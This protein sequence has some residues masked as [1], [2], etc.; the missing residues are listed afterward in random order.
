MTAEYKEPSLAEINTDGLLILETTS[1]LRFV[2]LVAV[3]F[4]EGPGDTSVTCNAI[5]S[6]QL[7]GGGEITLL[8]WLMR[9]A[10]LRSCLWT[11]YPDGANHC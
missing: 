6:A 3:H 10:R 4:T 1:C 8:Q 5:H 2:S 9:T 11:K 7:T